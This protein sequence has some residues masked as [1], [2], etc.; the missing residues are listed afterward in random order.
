[1]ATDLL[2]IGLGEVDN[3]ISVAEGKLAAGSLTVLVDYYELFGL[4]VLTLNGIPL[5]AVLIGDLAKVLLDNVDER[6]VVEMVVIDLSTEVDLALGS[7]LGI[8]TSSITAA[9]T[10]S[11]HFRLGR[12]SAAAAVVTSGNTLEVPI[13]DLLTLQ[14]RL[15]RRGTSPAITAT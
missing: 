4:T 11:R 13:V 2:A 15:A 14:A 1:V 10:G 9:T 7:D 8:K 12:S 5:H 6:V 3:G